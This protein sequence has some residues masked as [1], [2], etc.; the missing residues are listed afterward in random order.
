MLQIT[1]LTGQKVDE[2]SLKKTAN[3]ATAVLGKKGLEEISLVLVGDAKMRA[4]NKKYLNRD[5]V[6]D[7]LSFEE[8][9]EI[10]ICLPQAKR[11]VY[12]PKF[13]RRRA[14]MLKTS[15]NSELTRLLVHGIVHLKGYE[16][17][18]SKLAVLAMHKIEE[19]ILKKLH[20]QRIRKKIRRFF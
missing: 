18:R 3:K 13:Q 11:Q 19:K 2:A 12:P 16:H 9:N 15:L 5:R 10:F 6:T 17:E 14:K 4:L 7:V 20:G 8:L 1:N